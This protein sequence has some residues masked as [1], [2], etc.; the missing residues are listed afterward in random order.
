M[1]YATLEQLRD[2]IGEAELVTLSVL[3]S[4]DEIDAQRV[5]EALQVATGQADS[6][7]RTRYSV[8]LQTVPLEVRDA[9]LVLA[10][11]WLAETNPRT[12]ATETLRQAK[13]DTLK[14]LMALS[15]GR[16]TI[17]SASVPASPGASARVSD[18]ERR[19]DG[20][21]GRTWW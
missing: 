21:S 13:G 6:Y 17:E 11:A 1:P 4:G 2:R 14:W 19:F 8:P 18:R 16:V 3:G 7:L 12:V 15:D 20:G 5:A 10:Q 9:V